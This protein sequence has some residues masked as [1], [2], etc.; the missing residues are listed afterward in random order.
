MPKVL[1]GVAGKP[2]LGHILDAVVS[3][4][5]DEVILVVGYLG[6][7]VAEYVRRNY[8]IGVHY[9][10]QGERKGLGHAIYL[11][12][13]FTD[14]NP[15]LIVYGDT[16]FDAPLD[17]VVGRRETFIGVK[18]VDDPR[19]FGVVTTEG[20]R[21]TGFVEKPDMPVSNLAIVGINYIVTPT[22]LFEAL[23][24]II[25][26]DRKTKGE[27]QLTDALQVMLE[28]G[29]EMRT[30]QVDGWF[31][32]GKPETLL[33]TNHYLLERSSHYRPRERCIAIPPVFVADS[34]KVDNCIIGPD[35]TIDE[36]ADVR[37]AVIR[38]SIVSRKAKVRDVVLS[39][40]LIGASAEVHGPTTRLNVGDSS[41]VHF[42]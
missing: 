27:Y 12:R 5:V 41:E 11:T 37:S 33:E 7:Q 38:N 4:G 16:I 30:F 35:V 6:D 24:R 36:E 21:I 22:R 34:A 40:S 18:E 26:E 17:K 42:I 10:P 8:S 1:V 20:D 14:E 15:L 9:V 31:D 23:E 39:G 25:Q 13:E 2:I 3:A 28:E 29:E 32:C 19:R